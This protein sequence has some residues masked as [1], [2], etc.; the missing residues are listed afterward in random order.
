MLIVL[1]FYKR[2]P[3]LTYEQFSSH[4]RDVHGPLVRNTPDIAKYIRRYVQ[5]HLAPNTIFPGLS[6]LPYDGFSE[7]WFDSVEDHM[8]MRAEPI[9]REVMIPDEHLFLDMEM[10]K[11]TMLDNQVYQIADAPPLVALL[12]GGSPS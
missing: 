12:S 10:T 7:V 8:K 2:K 5:H 4:W 1:G 9:H 6:P 11:V 3:G